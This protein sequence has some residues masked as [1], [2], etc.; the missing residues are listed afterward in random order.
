MV[1]KETHLL[2]AGHHEG[3]VGRDVRGDLLGKRLQGKSS[4]LLANA[5]ALPASTK[6]LAYGMASRPPIIAINSVTDPTMF[7]GVS[8]GPG[9]SG[10]TYVPRRAR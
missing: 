7:A 2:R 3:N 5:S 10:R 4:H 8:P 6:A 1:R 9:N